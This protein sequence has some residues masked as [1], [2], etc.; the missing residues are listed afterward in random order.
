MDYKD[1]LNLPRTKF[2][3]KAN[4]AGKEPGILKKWEESRVYER[5]VKSRSGAPL[6]SF[7]DGP[8]YANGHI[9]YGHIL[10]KVL[11]DIIVKH[12]SM[13]GFLTRYIPGWDCHGL[14]IELAVEREK[15]V[16]EDP[17]KLREA[18]T[19]YAETF[20]RVQMG[21]FKRLGTFAAYDT[22]YKTIDPAYEATIIRALGS[23]MEDGA[24]YR[25][26][27][28]VFWC[29]D[30][31][32]ALAL[33]EIEYEDHD[34]DSIY[35]HFPVEDGKEKK[36]LLEACGLAG[37]DGRS[38]SVLIWTTTPWTL[39][40]NLAIALKPDFDYRLLEVAGRDGRTWLTLIA[41]KMDS[42]VRTGAKVK[43]RLVGE[44]VKG[45]Q[46]EG[47]RPRH[48]FEDR[49]SPIVLA[50]YVTL[51]TGTGAVHTAPG[52][53]AEDYMTGLKYKLPV[54]APVDGE[55]RFTDDVK[56]WKGRSVFDA[57]PLIVEHLDTSGYL[58]NPVGDRITHSYPHCWRCKKPV[59]F[60]ATAQWFISMDRTGIRKKA[61]AEIDTVR[62]IPEWGREDIKGKVEGRPDWCISRQRAWGVP[63]PFLYC[64]ACGEPHVDR[65]VAEKAARIFEKEGAAAWLKRDAADFMPEGTACKKCGS[66]AMRSETD[67]FDVWFESGVSWY[68]V[69][70]QEEDQGFENRD[71]KNGYV[72]LYLEGKDQHRGW[73]H[74]ALLTGIGVR[75]RAPYRQVL[76][77]G[78]V[79]DEDGRRYSK[80]KI[81][82]LKATGGAGSKYIPPDEIIGKYGAE[83]L[84][85][86]V[87]YEDFR[88]D[89]A[90]SENILARLTESY[91][92]IRNT[93][94]FL[95][96]NISD[97]DPGRHA[98][99]VEGMEL[100]DRW[101]LTRLQ[102]YVTRVR[103]AYDNYEFHRVVHDTAYFMNA[104]LSSFYLDILKDRLYCEEKDG[105]LRRSAQTVLHITAGAVC[106][107]LA[108]VLS[109]T[110]D[111]VWEHIPKTP[112]EP[113]SVFLAGFPRPEDIPGIP[114][115]A[116]VTGDMD[117]L[118]DVR[119]QVNKKLE[120][121]RA[122][123]LLG[124]SLEA[125]VGLR[126]EG[127]LFD[128]LKK[129]EAMLPDYF[130]VSAVELEQADGT[131]V[132]I[133]KAP[134]KKCARCWKYVVP[135]EGAGD[136]EICGR[137]KDVMSKMHAPG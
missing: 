86:W 61:S 21:E 59:I 123:K 11:K 49:D 51:D 53:G 97:F 129:H 114:D 136:G 106:R 93:F 14:P 30:C 43:G 134:D 18:C 82:K 40:A 91:R 10:N 60:R 95:L 39:P 54:Y 112:G 104:D 83:L 71:P 7:H 69:S 84:R 35:V 52:H 100:L 66:G 135:E 5:L 94:R 102:G 111:E 76:T 125:L 128:L 116:S 75:G 90:F 2:P 122:K 124:Q 37:D 115:A 74:T 13:D 56:L 131:G 46:L 55:G 19:K 92:K 3:M 117:R 27:M 87:A 98:V 101:A 137:C 12:K 99:A 36:R 17:L 70:V 42:M 8:P 113:E 130:I 109:F 22:P 50:D 33:A 68:A 108:P 126:A 9:H 15:G 16:I 44:K 62:W 31:H 45:K 58:L 103:K 63:L 23:F 67:I 6:F 133:K 78:F 47:L 1:S 118:K 41:E 121:S 80:S 85:L 24:V 88:T 26:S 105:G 120:E 34:S 64:D 119:D 81:E 72:D 77:H 79:V 28:P 127:V 25:S 48:P 110:S 57:N 73:F 29:V 38:L 107:L 132:E 65:A 32:T 20:I 4:L 89:I 96:G